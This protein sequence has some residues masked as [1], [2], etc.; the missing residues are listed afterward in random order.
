MHG[1]MIGGFKS[2]VPKTNGPSEAQN[3]R[4]ASCKC[5]AAAKK[6]QQQQDPLL[7]RVARG[8]GSPCFTVRH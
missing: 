6:K 4:G 1:G 3:G 5:Q 2:H 7:L 8:E